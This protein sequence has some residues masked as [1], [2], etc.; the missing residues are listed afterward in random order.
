MLKNLNTKHGFEVWIN[1]QLVDAIENEF[2]NVLETEDLYYYYS[3]CECGKNKEHKH[4][5][6]WVGKT[7]LIEFMKKV[8]KINN[9]FCPIG[10]TNAKNKAALKDYFDHHFYEQESP[11][12]D[13]W[14][15]DVVG[16]KMVCGDEL[17]ISLWN[18]V[19]DKATK[20]AKT[21]KSY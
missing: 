15:G 5:V 17:V 4:E 8:Q 18:R 21:N 14:I 19:K 3:P 20:D 2:K 7:T 11:V 6:K 13:Y 9:R 10:V 1:Q 12:W 16:D